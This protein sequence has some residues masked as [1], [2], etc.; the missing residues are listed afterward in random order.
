MATP[1]HVKPTGEVKALDVFGARRAHH[2]IASR[3]NTV[4]FLHLVYY[5]WVAVND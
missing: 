4:V 2:T 5:R 1:S 3:V